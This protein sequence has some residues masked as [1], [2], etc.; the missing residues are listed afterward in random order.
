MNN[1]APKMPND[2]SRTQTFS[3]TIGSETRD[4]E[5]RD[6]WGDGKRFDSCQAVGAYRLRAGAKV[7]AERVTFWRQEDGSYR[8]NRS[9]TI[10]NRSGYPL[11][12]WADKIKPDSHGA[13]KHNSA[14]Q[15]PAAR[16]ST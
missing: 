4:V 2:D 11:V 13:S 7:W 15:V 1:A 5:A 6:V 10:L 16:V 9:T 14:V 8:A 3:L 12:G